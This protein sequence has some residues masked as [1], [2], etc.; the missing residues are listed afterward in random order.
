MN[1][2]SDASYRFCPKCAGDLSKKVPPSEHVERFVCLSCNFIFYQNP[3]PTAGI[4]LADGNK[5]LLVK[6]SIEP[7]KGEWDIPGGFIEDH[8][9]PLD[10]I[11][12]EIMEELGVKIEVEKFLGIFMD[13][14]G[15]SGGSTLNIYYTGK[16]ISG[17]P[18]PH[19][20]ICECK[21]FPNG[22]LPSRLA[23]KN[24]TEAL[25]LWK[26]NVNRQNQDNFQE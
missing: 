8:E 3:K 19:D 13:K 15:Y 12:R 14:Y 4:V 20:D 6:R 26:E 11:N 24:N 23:F 5:I 21:W 7:A 16:I 9:H 1:C 18:S 10:T 2:F 22:E 25:N 17:T